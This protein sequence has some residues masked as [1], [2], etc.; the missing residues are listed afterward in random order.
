MPAPRRGA[1]FSYRDLLRPGLPGRRQ[2]GSGP[3]LSAQAACRPAALAPAGR[4]RGSGGGYRPT[5][6]RTAGVDR[7]FL[8]RPADPVAARPGRLLRA[9]RGAPP[10]RPADQCGGQG[11]DSGHTAPAWPRDWRVWRR[12]AHG[13]QRE[14]ERPRSGLRSEK[15]GFGTVGRT[16]G[17]GRP[18]RP[19]ACR[20]G[21]RTAG[22]APS[23]LVEPLPNA[24]EG[25]QKRLR[26]LRAG[27]VSAQAL[28]RA[29]FACV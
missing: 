15:S 20:K 11:G 17:S 6:S 27:A 18:G 9:D 7:A 10:A 4:Q 13:Q 19:V 26:L 8:A 14:S 25:G 2:R 29:G 23:T 24:G 1:D 12:R 5:G 16:G 3:Y 21:G 22:G 28:A